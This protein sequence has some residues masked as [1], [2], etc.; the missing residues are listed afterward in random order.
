MQTRSA[1]NAGKISGSGAYS[2]LELDRKN[3]ARRVVKKE[4]KEGEEDE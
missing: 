3:K 4:I 1:V 2:N